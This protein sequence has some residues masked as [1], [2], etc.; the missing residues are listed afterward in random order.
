MS[1]LSAGMEPG[2]G[3]GFD[4]GGMLMEHCNLLLEC[5]AGQHGL[6]SGSGGGVSCNGH[7]WPSLAHLFKRL[8]NQ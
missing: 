7:H 1:R 5:K 3:E 4:G 2:E 8:R 6:K